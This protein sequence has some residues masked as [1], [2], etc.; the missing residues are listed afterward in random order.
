MPGVQ[1]AFNNP[2]YGIRVTITVL[3]SQRA[4]LSPAERDCR[5]T[6]QCGGKSESNRPVGV[7][8]L[9]PENSEGV[10]QKAGGGSKPPPLA[11]CRQGLL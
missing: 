8:Q 2:D 3:Q 11:E 7:L 5:E 4:E 1:Q 6:S 10:P 9:W